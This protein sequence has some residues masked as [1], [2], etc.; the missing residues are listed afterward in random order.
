MNKFVKHK[1][2]AMFDLLEDTI[3]E[4]A[5][6]LLDVL[7]EEE[8][9]SNR[10]YNRALKY[11]RVVHSKLKLENWPEIASVLAEMREHHKASI[12]PGRSRTPGSDQVDI[13]KYTSDRIEERARNR[14]QW[15]MKL[16]ISRSMAIE[17]LESIT[18]EDITADRI[19]FKLLEELRKMAAAPS[20]I[21]E[22][23]A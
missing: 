5:Y 9:S 2:Q 4:S 17:C 18:K 19:F 14:E 8:L 7:G 22:I 21:K 11:A 10:Y 1:S 15:L 6:I 20:T 12:S 16:L 13:T 3:L 23:H